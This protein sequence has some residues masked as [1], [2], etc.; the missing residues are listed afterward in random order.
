MVF[1]KL[2][3]G[4]CAGEFFYITCDSLD[5]VWKV[6]YVCFWRAEVWRPLQSVWI[7]WLSGRSQD[8]IWQRYVVIR[9][10]W[11]SVSVQHDS[12]RWV[13]PYVCIR[14]TERFR[15]MRKWHI[16]EGLVSI[17]ESRSYA[18]TS[19]SR[20]VGRDGGSWGDTNS[21]CFKQSCKKKR[22]SSVV[23]G[24]SSRLSENEPILVQCSVNFN[25]KKKPAAVS[26]TLSQIR[27]WG[28]IHDRVSFQLT[29]LWCSVCQHK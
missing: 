28:I 20:S 5:E 1:P 16:S 14:R 2:P 26:W 3:T 4:T 9:V 17:W 21:H 8:G 27:M 15:L 13:L 23:L 10:L 7:Q 29:A 19:L 25:C 18:D 24:F 11:I 6:V 22:N 12:W